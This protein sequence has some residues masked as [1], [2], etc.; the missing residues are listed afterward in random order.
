VIHGY[1]LV[2]QERQQMKKIEIPSNLT[3]LAYNSIK[4]H[5]LEGRLDQDTKLTESRLSVQLGISR[6][7]V[8]EALNS[9]E[10]EGL[11]R[12]E[13]RRG[14]FLKRFSAKEISDLYDLRQ[15]LEVYAVRTAAITPGLLADLEESVRRTREL[16]KQDKKQEFIEEDMKFH[17]LITEATGNQL[18]CKFLANIQNQIWLCRCKTYNMSSSRAPGGHQAIIEAL[19]DKDRRK[20]ESAMAEH[21]AYVRHKL[22]NLVSEQQSPAE[23]KSGPQTALPIE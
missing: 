19:R 14:A 1:D 23:I 8:R 5:I 13:S 21:I 11:I 20:A 22:V 7:P 6:S 12:I 2:P 4:Q 15:V 10:A 3:T 18:L 17:G 9:L 16:S